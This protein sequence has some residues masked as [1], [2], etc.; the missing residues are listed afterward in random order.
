MSILKFYNKLLNPNF[1]YFNATKQVG[2][3]YNFYFSRYITDFGDRYS[4]ISLDSDLTR[5]KLNFSKQISNHVLNNIHEKHGVELRL[6]TIK[7]LDLIFCN[8]EKFNT[9]KIIEGY[10][11]SHE[12]CEENGKYFRFIYDSNEKSSKIKDYSSTDY[13][14]PSF[15][16]IYDL[17]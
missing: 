11:V 15:R 13:F 4:F 2:Y 9:G 17:R 14:K 6:P 12:I 1:F 3:G 7:E 8:I 16:L 10:S 5:N